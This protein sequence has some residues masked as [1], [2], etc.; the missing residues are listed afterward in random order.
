[1]T[2]DLHALRFLLLIF[3]G[4]VNRHQPRVI[5]YLVEENRILKEQVGGRRVRLTDDQRRLAS[6]AKGLG[7]QTLD[8]I[9][10]I[11]T[12]DTLMRWYRHLI[13]L[14]WTY[15]GDVGRRGV[16]G[17]GALHHSRPGGRGGG[18]ADR[19]HRF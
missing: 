6:L 14:K 1:M 8:Q 2:A 16:A 17:P 7:R 4:W 10:T 13:A 18:A 15:K 3:A 12:P 19:G 11:V 9:A 5:E